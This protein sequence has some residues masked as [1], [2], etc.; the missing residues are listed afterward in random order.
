MSTP[1]TSGAWTLPD[2][3]PAAWS[4]RVVDATS[5]DLLLDHDADRQLRTASVGKIFLLIEAARQLA[6]GRL[7]G[8]ERLSWRE[9]EL[10]ADSGLWHRLGQ[11]ELCV[12]DVCTLV[13]AVSDNLATNVLVRRLGLDAPARTARDLGCRRTALLDRI[14]TERGPGVPPT[15]SVGTAAELSGLLVRLHRG[16]VYGAEVSSRVRGWLAG[17]T[18]LSMVAAAFDLDPLA[19]AEPDRGVALANKTGTISTAR[20]D[21]GLVSGPAGAVAYAV[22]A[23]WDDDADPRDAVL[24]TMRAIGALIRDRVKP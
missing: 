16:E 2:L 22:G 1:V 9:D 14:R 13:G 17:N 21:V 8:A 18:D 23:N 3:P 20:I 4:I 24:A 11:R 5:G 7:D 19:H 15:T 6:D 10:V 12:A